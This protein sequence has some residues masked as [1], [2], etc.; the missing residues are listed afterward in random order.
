MTPCSKHFVS[1]A[2]HVVYSEVWQLQAHSETDVRHSAGMLSRANLDNDFL[3]PVIATQ[4]QFGVPL[5]T[6]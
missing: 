3:I 1:K 6:V 2:V 5:L 4:A